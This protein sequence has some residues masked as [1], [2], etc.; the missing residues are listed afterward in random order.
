MASYVNITLDTT[1]P[2]GVTISI[3]S[4]AVYSNSVDVTATIATSDTPTTGYTMKVWGD[5]DTSYGGNANYHTGAT[6]DESGATWYAFSTS[7][8]VRLSATDGTK[9]LYTKV[10]D[11][12]WNESATASATIIL[13]T[14]VPVVTVTSGPTATRVS[15]VAGKRTTSFDWQSDTQFDVYKV[16]VVPT[17]GSL[18]GA[19]TV[20]PT[21]NGSSNTSGS[22]QDY[23]ATTNITTTIDGRDLE[24]A[25][26]GAGNDGTKIT[27][28]FVQ[29]D[30]GNWSI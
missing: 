15:K 2:A 9:T 10:R 5:V 29:D 20:V 16:K 14:T 8:A 4:A 3:N 27:K 7:A 18:E 19:G 11:D 25:S 12:V 1:A 22:A 28:V 26:G 13:D 23:P 24:T 21:T 17:T 30:A 6:V